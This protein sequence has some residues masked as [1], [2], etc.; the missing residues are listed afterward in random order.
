MPPSACAVHSGPSMPIQRREFLALAAADNPAGVQL[1]S[2]I[3][4]NGVEIKV[5][6]NLIGPHFKMRYHK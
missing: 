3:R 2:K 1:G 5:V 6:M 4:S